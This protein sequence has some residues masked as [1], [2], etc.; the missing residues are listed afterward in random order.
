MH[1]SGPQCIYLIHALQHNTSGVGSGV[2]PGVRVPPCWI[3]LE[4]VHK[5]ETCFA[6]RIYRAWNGGPSL[7]QPPRGINR[8]WLHEVLAKKGFGQ[9]MRL[10]LRCN[11][12]AVKVW[13]SC[14]FRFKTSNLSDSVISQAK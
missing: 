13:I 7:A 5:R 1:I 8:A 11:K 10:E 9:C 2:A 6:G 14:D 12:R 3:V 4:S